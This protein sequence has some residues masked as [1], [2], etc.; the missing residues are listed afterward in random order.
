MFFT[1]KSWILAEGLKESVALRYFIYKC[2]NVYLWTN[3]SSNNV[4]YAQI[5][6]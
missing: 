3:K 5:E 6:F 2:N 4:I 1:P